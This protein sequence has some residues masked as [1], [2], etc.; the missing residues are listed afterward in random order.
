MP[1]ALDKVLPCNDAFLLRLIGEFR[2]GGGGKVGGGGK[3]DGGGKAGGGGKETRGAV[4]G[5]GGNIGGGGSAK[6]LVPNVLFPF[7]V[8]GTE[9]GGGRTPR[10]LPRM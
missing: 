3:E 10:E 7:G 9:P 2:A 6:E 8:A 1:A 5:G 4:F